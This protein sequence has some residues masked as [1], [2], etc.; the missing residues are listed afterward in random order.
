MRKSLPR[1]FQ[2]RAEYRWFPQS[3]VRITSRLERVSTG[4]GRPRKDAPTQTVWSAAATVGRVDETR[5]E[6]ERQRR[7]TFV[8]ITTLPKETWK[9][10]QV[11]R[12][13]KDQ[14]LCE[15][16]FHFIKDAPFLDTPERLE[17]LGYVILMAA[18]LYSLLGRRRRQRPVAIP[19]PARR[20]LTR[21]TAHELFRHLATVQT[22]VQPD[23]TRQVSLPE[24]FHDTFV[25][26]LE[27]LQLDERCYTRPPRP[28]GPSG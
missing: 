2:A 27:A 8:L 18:L 24:R 28:C 25:A 13:Y 17:A 3:S 23:G 4:R 7:S 16:K 15:R 14:V 26:F 6:S 5:R 1:A 22:E 12:E 21:P 20:V 19:S 9:A 11:L 10:E